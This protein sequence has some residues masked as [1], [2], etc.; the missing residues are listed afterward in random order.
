[1]L[2][3]IEVPDLICCAPCRSSQSPSTLRPLPTPYCLPSRLVL[4]T[5]ATLAGAFPFVGMDLPTSLALF[6][7]LS[8]PMM[9]STAT[10]PIQNKSRLFSHEARAWTT[11]HN[12]SQRMLQSSTAQT[13]LPG[14]RVAALQT[15]GA[16]PGAFYHQCAVYRMQPLWTSLTTSRRWAWRPTA[17]IGTLTPSSCFLSEER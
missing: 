11:A 5:T 12:V 7:H 2:C 4:L 14:L 17:P 10:M 15:S 6:T 1:M 16:T 8:D 9:L 3:R 13:R